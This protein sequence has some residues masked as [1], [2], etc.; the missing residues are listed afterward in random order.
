MSECE[1][2]RG[3]M[4]LTEVVS[5]L[6]SVSLWPSALLWICGFEIQI[7][8]ELAVCVFTLDY[9]CEWM[10]LVYCPVQRCTTGRG[11]SNRLSVVSAVTISSL[12]GSNKWL[13]IIE[14][15]TKA[16]LRPLK[17]KKKGVTHEMETHLIFCKQYWERVVGQGIVTVY[18]L[19]D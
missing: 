10:C 1:E 13:M 6:A 7:Y 4:L 11:R 2:S 12:C 8:P 5:K 17:K 14:V 16:G 18:I 15:K 3:N 19:L 9:Q